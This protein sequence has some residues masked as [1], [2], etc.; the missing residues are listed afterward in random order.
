[1]KSSASEPA[2][3]ENIPVRKTGKYGRR[4]GRRRQGRADLPSPLPFAEVA[5]GWLLGQGGDRRRLYLNQMWKNWDMVMGAELAPVALPLGH[6]DGVLLVGAEDHFLMQDLT[7]AVPEILERANAFMQ[8][9]MFHKVELR[10]LGE[11]QPLNRLSPS[12][13]PVSPPPP[14]PPHLGALNLDPESPVGRCYAAYL[15]LFAI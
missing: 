3:V 11:S 6:R 8:E 7:Y 14:R 15:K 5:R 4:R 13:V 9:N 1:M 12:P 2:P 10:L